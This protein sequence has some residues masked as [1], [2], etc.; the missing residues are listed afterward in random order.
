MIWHDIYLLKLGFHQVA[1]VGKLVQ[2]YKGTA[3]YERRNNT[4][5][6]KNTEYKK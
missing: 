3:V 6:Y 5:K 4:K 2:K 1:V